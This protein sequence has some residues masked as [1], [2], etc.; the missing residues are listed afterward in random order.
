MQQPL[1][2]SNM[3]IAPHTTAGDMCQTNWSLYVSCDMTAEV[4]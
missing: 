1:L 4:H 2:I 3:I